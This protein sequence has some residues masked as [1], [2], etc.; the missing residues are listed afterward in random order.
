[1]ANP[2]YKRLCLYLPGQTPLSAPEKIQMVLPFKFFLSFSG[3]KKKNLHIICPKPMQ[4]HKTSLKKMN[5]K[6]EF[7]L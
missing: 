3:K 5:E 1:M 6:S 2:C 4:K 7:V